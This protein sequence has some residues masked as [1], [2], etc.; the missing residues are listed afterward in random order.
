MIGS[1]T[2]KRKEL[3]LPLSASR[4]L[5]LFRLMPIAI[6]S[7]NMED[8]LRNGQQLLQLSEFL[9]Q[10]MLHQNTKMVERTQSMFMLLAKQKKVLEKL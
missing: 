3:L 2:Q 9:S 4:V 5:R 7:K 6:I 10:I 1:E 8:S